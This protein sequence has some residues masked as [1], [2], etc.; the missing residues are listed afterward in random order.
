MTDYLGYMIIGGLVL[1]LFI[2]V[3]TYLSKPKC[4]KCKNRNAD[5]VKKE[6]I[7][8][9]TVYFKDEE[10]I[11]EYS[12]P[13]GAVTPV[14]LGAQTIKPPERIIT[15]EVKIPGTRKWYR[16]IYRCKI[17]GEQF[18]QKEYKDEKPTIV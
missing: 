13:D 9:E 8:E 1:I 15:K 18:S 17:C 11:K 10:T 4:P 6:F 3:C 14:G 12:N 7:R 5:F 16:V 2:A